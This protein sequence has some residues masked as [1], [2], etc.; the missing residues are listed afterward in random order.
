LEIFERMGHRYAKDV[1]KDLEALEKE[2]G[3][4][5]SNR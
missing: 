4:T 2:E 5:E 3:S 1:R